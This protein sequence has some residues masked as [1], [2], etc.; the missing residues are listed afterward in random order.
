V[1]Q[2]FFESGH[3]EDPFRMA[4]PNINIAVNGEQREVPPGLSVSALLSHLQVDSGR[5]ALERNLA[6]LPRAEWGKTQVQPGDRF[7]IV[8]FVGGGVRR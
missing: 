1:R 2:T 6:I 5:V 3:R 4:E 7:E 8:H